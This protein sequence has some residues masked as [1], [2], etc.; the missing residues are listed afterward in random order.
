MK[1]KTYLAFLAVVG[2]LILS[3][4]AY[5]EEYTNRY[6]QDNQERSIE[7]IN[8][9]FQEIKTPAFP[10]G[11][12]DQNDPHVQV[13][14][15]DPAVPLPRFLSAIKEG[16]T[17]QLAILRLLS[18]PNI[19]WR[20]PVSDEEKWVYYW[21]W[22]YKN[23]FDPNETIIYMNHEGK[24]VKH[25]SK[26]VVMVVTFDKNDVVDAFKIRLLKVKH[27]AFDEY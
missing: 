19:I 2:T 1:T 24:K 9:G 12:V 20:D 21:M 10:S 5:S 14:G 6:V 11:H 27:D 18:A 26:P 7:G 16:Q 25:N 23:E 15:W 8:H 17:D 3:G 4:S 22:S 13:L